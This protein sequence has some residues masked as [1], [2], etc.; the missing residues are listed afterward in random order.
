MA[1]PKGY[2]LAR[3]I[4]GM[5]GRVDRTVFAL[6]LG[7]GALLAALLL[8]LPGV[9]PKWWEAAVVGL[10]LASCVFMVG[11]L[12]QAG[13]HR[14]LDWFGLALGGAIIAAALV[15]GDRSFALI[16]TGGLVLA[17]SIRWMRTKRRR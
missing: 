12:E 10:A 5:T 7:F 16:L 2:A 14:Q 3:I 11:S 13:G 9:G 1:R 17:L 4:H 8:I 6:S 15:D